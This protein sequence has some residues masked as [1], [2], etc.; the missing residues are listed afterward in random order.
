MK[1]KNLLLALL[2]LPLL[3]V[4]CEPNNPV[5]EVKDPTVTVTAGATTESTIAFTVAS[6]DA[7]KVA[8]LVVEG[9]EAPTASE[10]LANGVAVEANKSVAVTATELKAETDYTIVAAA[11]NSKGVVKSTAT[12][13]T[14][15]AGETP[16]PEPDP[17]PTPDP[18]PEPTPDPDVETFVATHYAADFDDSEGFYMY[19]ITLGDKEFGS[20]GWGVNGGTYYNIYFIAS[21]KNNGKLPLGTY[22][23]SFA[24]NTNTVV[25]DYSTCYYMN[26]GELENYSAFKE[27]NLVISENKIE[28]SAVLD[29][30]KETVVKVVYEGALTV[31]DGTGSSAVEAI[32]L[33]ATDWVWGGPTNYGNKYQAVGEGF[34]VDVHF[35]TENATKTSLTAGEY[36]WVGTSFWDS[37]SLTEFTTRTLVVDGES[38]AVDGGIAVVDNED[39]YY[40]IEVTLE[41]R[42]GAT[43][44]VYYEGKLADEEEGGEDEV[45]T[46]NATSLSEGTYSASVYFY[47]FK[48]AGEGFSFDLIVNDY[49]AFPDKI[50]AGSYTH[51]PGKSYAGGKGYFFVDNLKVDGI[52]YKATEASTMVVEGDGTNVDITI[53]FSATVGKQFVLKYAGKV[54]GSAN[55][56][57]DDVVEPTKLATPTVV[58]LVDGNA[59]T[60][61]W[62]EIDGAKDYTVTLD[63]T[64]VNTVETAYITYQDLG[65]ETEHTVTVVANP[66][67]AALNLASDAGTT[68]FTTEANPNPGE[69]GDDEPS[70][71]GQS[72]EGW[73]FSATLDQGAK[74][75][76]V[77]DGSHTV[78]FTI[79]QVSSGTFYILDSGVLN[80]TKV[81]VNGVETTDASGT[82]MMST[83][84]SYHVTLNATINGVRYT[85][86]SSNAVV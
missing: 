84:N 59:A 75:I 66:A 57:G 69:G 82:V 23:L 15:A 21:K 36:I 6:T 20:T 29:N 5:D 46:L 62:N 44:L 12:A 18:E 41:G 63:G 19:G 53:N 25:G 73:Q 79:N 39:D 65:W 67:D 16:N 27:A 64:K 83:N 43:Y 54:G 13:K 47:T 78:E 32:E 38:V 3:F 49:A 30:G 86:T 1:I 17:E 4:A 77:T 28:F 45:T 2:A 34:S 7:E 51:A 10:V 81:V 14:L 68:T 76:T 71:G 74:L 58:G 40:F 33:I 70:T 72:F 55:E 80:I 35:P 56:G 22:S 42:N 8:Y 37:N 11:Q 85:G 60:I 61:S 24:Y 52:S 9:A 48:A 50:L 31:D 26:N